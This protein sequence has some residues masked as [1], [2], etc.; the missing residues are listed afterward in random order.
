MR[1]VATL[2]VS[3]LLV[4]SSGTNECGF[5]CDGAGITSCTRLS[6]DGIID[7]DHDIPE[8][9]APSQGRLRSRSVPSK[10]CPIRPQPVAG[11]AANIMSLR[12]YP[13]RVRRSST[14]RRPLAA[15]RPSLRRSS[16]SP[17]SRGTP[18]PVRTVN[19]LDRDDDRAPTLCGNAIRSLNVTRGGGAHAQPSRSGVARSKSEP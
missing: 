11:L 8:G 5:G 4:G 1:A 15:G 12:P 19:P 16:G 18:A 14:H 2:R 9:P 7:C 13:R 3:I 6:L 10:T 17:A